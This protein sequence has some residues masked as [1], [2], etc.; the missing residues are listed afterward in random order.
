VQTFGTKEGGGRRN[1]SRI[2]APLPALLITMS[3]RHPAILFN[4]SRSGALLCAKNA[5]ATGTELFL[6]VGNLDVYARVA[7]KDGERCGIKFDH[8][9]RHWD[10]EQLRTLA[11]KGSD[12][13]L[14]AA[15][16]GG[17]DDWA[18]GVAR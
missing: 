18:A 15:E 1:S 8:D 9:I 5:P 2:S 14:H 17:A 7:W 16:I 11:G 12:A 10:V 3:D 4:I 13:R 6:Q